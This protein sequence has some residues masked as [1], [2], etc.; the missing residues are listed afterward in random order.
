ME[1]EKQLH[2]EVVKN[3]ALTKGLQAVL[4]GTAALTQH[5]SC[6]TLFQF[7]EGD[8]RQ[9]IAQNKVSAAVFFRGRW[10]VN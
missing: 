3:K 4:A 6:R 8:E 7:A 2:S 5:C 9:A 1:C 10:D